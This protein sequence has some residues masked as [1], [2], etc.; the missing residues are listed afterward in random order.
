MA[1][2]QQHHEGRLLGEL[3]FWLHILQDHAMFIEGNLPFDRPDL[4]ERARAFAMLFG[5]LQMR[6][7]ADSG[8]CELGQL[9]LDVRQATEEFIVFKRQLL[10]LVIQCRLDQ[11]KNHNF[12]LF[13]DHIAREASEFLRFLDVMAAQ[14]EP[15]FVKALRE[16]VFWLRIMKEHA[17]FIVHLL[18][19]S[20]LGFIEEA[21]E[22]HLLFDRLLDQARDLASMLQARPENFP[23]V[24]RFTDEVLDATRDLRDFKAAA[25]Q[26]I[27]ECRLLILAPAELA[28]H[29][30]REANHFLD[31]L[32]AIR[33]TL[34]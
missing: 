13:L 17:Q 18:D 5:S 23:V 9:V 14:G 11:G 27:A 29:V 20:E 28:D 2:R 3:Q 26:L 24:T 6:A 8:H 7:E 15:P 32:T 31:A 19:P 10:A 16:E 21:H 34:P 33:A 1:L 25:R 4:I 22:F 12:A 30:M